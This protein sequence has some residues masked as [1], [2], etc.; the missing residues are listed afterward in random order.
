MTKRIPTLDNYIKESKDWDDFDVE[1]LVKG[2]K[3]DHRDLTDPDDINDWLSM[4]AN[5]KRIEDGLSNW[6]KEE[7]VDAICKVEKKADS[8]K[9]LAE[10]Y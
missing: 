10:I 5:D 6:Y 4:F 9:L 7:L 1:T 3:R 2:L 8:K